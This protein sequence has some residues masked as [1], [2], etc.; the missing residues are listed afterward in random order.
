M[1]IQVSQTINAPC[2]Q[3]W[4]AV[5]DRD[6]LLPALRH[7]QMTRQLG[8][9]SYAGQLIIP[10][11]PVGGTYEGTM[12]ISQVVPPLQFQVH[13]SGQGERGTVNGN[14]RVHLEEINQATNIHFE[15]EIDVAGELAAL[16]SR[17]L[18]SN[19]NAIVRRSLK[20]VRNVIWPERY[21]TESV[22]LTRRYEFGL[23]AQTKTAVLTIA[24]I[25]VGT[26]LVRVI[27]K[28]LFKQTP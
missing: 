21:V 24:T 28:K 5:M 22:P 8:D 19:A 7:L 6:K 10:V 20:A 23:S 17:L 26:L 14:G 1:K 25:L 11:G 2:N 13:F 15:G 18:Q 12:T 3:V 9:G 27:S 16:P 4:S